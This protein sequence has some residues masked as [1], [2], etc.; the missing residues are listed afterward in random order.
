MILSLF[1]GVGIKMSIN[2]VLGMLILEPLFY[3]LIFV[4]SV[5]KS[6]YRIFGMHISSRV[7]L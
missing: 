1:H 3:A 7:E 6:I 5:V 4:I 2:S